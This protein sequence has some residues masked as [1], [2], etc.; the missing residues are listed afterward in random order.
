MGYASQSG[1]ARTS[2]RNP[3]AHAICDRCGF[4]FNHV[5]LQWQMDY[6]G[7]GIINKR[8]LVCRSCNDEPQ[9]QLR[10]III[11]ADPVPISNPRVQDFTLSSQDRRVTSG[12]DTTNQAT[13][14]PVPG[15]DVRITQDGDTRVVQQTGAAPG[16][17]NQE[18]GTDPNVNGPT[19]LPPDNTSVPKTGPLT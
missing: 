14:I 15:G 17:L 12:Q 7:S 3:Q 2:A 10:A 9:S 6:A 1:R 13:G 4:R 11:P 5:N 18:P 8:L 19:N 16:S